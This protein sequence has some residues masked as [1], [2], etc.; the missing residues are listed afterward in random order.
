MGMMGS[1]RPMISRPPL[2]YMGSKFRLCRRI[3]ELCPQH[4]GCVDAFGG[5]AGFLLPKTPT[6]YDVYN[7]VDRAMVNL[8]RVLRAPDQAAE[9]RKLLT[10]T[11]YARQ[12]FEE[13]WALVD[14][15]RRGDESAG[16]IL[17]AWATLIRSHYAIWGGLTSNCARFRLSGGRNNCAMTWA[18]LP[19]T[20]EQVTT[21]L[22]NVTI[23]NDTALRVIE[24][25]DHPGRLIYCDPPYPL[26]T[27]EC[28]T[29]THRR[30]YTFEMTD[31]DH[32]EMAKALRA[33]RGYVIVSSY[34][35]ELYDKA[36]RGW[37]KYEFK[38]RHKYPSSEEVSERTEVVWLSP[39]T[40]KALENERGL[41]AAKI[42]AQSA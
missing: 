1:M 42:G 5:G 36:F 26:S 6:K 38:T 30:G 25:Y 37:Q 24:R 13:A 2:R 9:L 40:A 35:S 20:L 29:Y 11:L 4:D 34:P 31:K 12:E 18:N 19:Q 41:K 7:D 16:S 32:L 8:F 33:C 21:R 23:E 22:R 10:L 27:R 3:F 39:A 14:R 17:T 28:R 15:F